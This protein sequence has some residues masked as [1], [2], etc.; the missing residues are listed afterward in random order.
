MNCLAQLKYSPTQ[1]KCVKIACNTL[2]FSFF[3]QDWPDNY[4]FF[5][6]SFSPTWLLTLFTLSAPF[7]VLTLF[8]NPFYFFIPCYHLPILCFSTTCWPPRSLFFVFP[9]VPSFNF[10]HQGFSKGAYLSFYLFFFFA[11]VKP[12]CLPKHSQISQSHSV[13]SESLVKQTTAPLINQYPGLQI[14]I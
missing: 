11:W 13:H 3:F 10:H 14:K 8:A 4:P 9:L 5:L 7:S 6:Q 12:L 2:M 1:Y